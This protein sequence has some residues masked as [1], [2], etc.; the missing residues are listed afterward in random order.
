[1]RGR[2][3]GEAE[4]EHRERMEEELLERLIGAGRRGGSGGD[5]DGGRRGS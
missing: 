2:V 1:M 4:G 3:D 5:G